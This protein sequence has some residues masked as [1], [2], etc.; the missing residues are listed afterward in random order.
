M[1]QYRNLPVA[2]DVTRQEDDVYSLS[3]HNNTDNRG[4]GYVPQKISIR[5]K[6]KIWIS[7]LENQQELV[8]ALIAEISRLQPEEE[9]KVY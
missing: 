6:G 2:Y 4:D 8:N 1:V 5:R 7:D 9:G 3:L